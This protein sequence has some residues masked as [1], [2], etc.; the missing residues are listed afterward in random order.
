MLSVMVTM[1]SRLDLNFLKICLSLNVSIKRMGS[2]NKGKKK[3]KIGVNLQFKSRVWNPDFRLGCGLG[4][5]WAWSRDFSSEL[6]LG[7]E[8]QP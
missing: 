8:S 5:S 4:R 3:K 1:S 7:L 6:G 2:V